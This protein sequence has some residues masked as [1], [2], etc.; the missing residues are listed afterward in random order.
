MQTRVM[1]VRVLA[2]ACAALALAA[3]SS[4]G[5]AGD[6]GAVE[7]ATASGA[8]AGVNACSPGP[9][10][11]SPLSITDQPDSWDY[12]G[13]VGAVYNSSGKTLWLSL[14]SAGTTGSKCRLDNG[15]RAAYAVS[16]PSDRDVLLKVW[17]GEGSDATYSQVLIEDGNVMYPTLT[18]DGAIND[19]KS[20]TRTLKESMTMRLA[21]G[22]KQTIPSSQTVHASYAGGEYEITRLDD[23]GDVA[24]EWTAAGKWKSGD[25]A[26]IDVKITKAPFCE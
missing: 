25:W 26:R 3:C 24:A 18:F 15:Q 14:T 21:E 13:A 6:G 17:D 16:T 20:C 12:D 1:G 23:D 5:S 19:T 22:D 9:P 2:V 8:V 11:G 7:S 4:G 10:A